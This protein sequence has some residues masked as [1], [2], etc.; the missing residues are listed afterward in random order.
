[1]L[2]QLFAVFLKLGPSTF[3]GGY[4]MITAIERE[5][6]EKKKW[7]NP[8]EVGDMVSVAG[9]APGGVAVNSAA[10]VGYRLAGVLGAVTA[11]IG[12]T[13]PTF[14]IVFILSIFGM[15]FKEIPK[16]EAAL[17]GVH[18]AVVALIIVA[19]FKVGKTSIID[20]A[21]LIIAGIC[22]LVLLFTPLN[23]LYLILGGPLLG[24]T[25]ISVKR[26]MGY[27]APTEKEEKPNKLELN[28]PEY[29]I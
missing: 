11:V 13:L 9:S 4:A 29:Y 17:K 23:S 19:A 26:A 1:M 5:I 20:T 7:L 27:S 14:A 18:A 25:V 2:I 10:F 24:V 28:Y 15:M 21:T 6:V 12:I 16:V 22:V 3:G 8:G